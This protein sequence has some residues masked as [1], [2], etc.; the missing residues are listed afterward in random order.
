MP[1]QQLDYQTPQPLSFGTSPWTL[2]TQLAVVMPFLVA[3]VFIVGTAILQDYLVDGIPHSWRRAALRMAIPTSL[4]TLLALTLLLRAMLRPTMNR[5]IV[6]CG[7]V[8]NCLTLLLILDGVAS[9]P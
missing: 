1:Q 4:V 5:W 9:A 6:F 8:L 3:P 2:A 7:L